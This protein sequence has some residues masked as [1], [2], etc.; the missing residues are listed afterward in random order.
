[1]NHDAKV[2]KSFTYPCVGN[3]R[4]LIRNESDRS[5]TNVATS[6]FSNEKLMSIF[7]L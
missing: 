4:N 6:R 5:A 3:R 2:F 7:P 1:L